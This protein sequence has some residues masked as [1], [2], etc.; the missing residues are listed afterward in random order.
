MKEKN[1]K[2]LFVLA[3]MF[4]GFNLRAALTGVGP[5]VSMIQS[6]LHLSSGATGF[7]TTIPLLAFAAMSLLVSKISAK[8][9]EGK[10]IL[11]SFLIM[12]AGLLVR[13]YLGTAGLFLGTVLAGIGI[14]FGNVL[15]PVIIKGKFPEKAAALTSVYTA[16]MGLFA[17]ISA[18]ISA[19]LALHVGW[20]NSMA[21]WA[22]LV[23]IGIL[24][25][26]PFVPMKMKQEQ[27]DAVKGLFKN[28]IAIWLS[29]FM[30]LQSLLFY[31]FVAWLP[32]I[33]AVKGF[34]AEAAGYLFSI[35]QVLGIPASFITPLLAGR[36]NDQ[37]WV[38]CLIAGAY[39]LGL[40]MITA[41]QVKAV[42]GIG[43]A[44]C[45]FCSGCC[46]S[47]AM[48]MINT[49]ASNAAVSGQLSGMS[50]AAGY[51]LAAVGPSAMGV[52]FDMTQNWTITLTI[53]IVI[54]IPLFM[55]GWNAAKDRKVQNPIEKG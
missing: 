54:M 2:V 42:I 48:L 11:L 17:S 47:I 4:I 16:S 19:P 49:R 28:P 1:Q 46:L 5:L 37:R 10:T 26:L 18:A 50:Q 12:A 27:G 3:I 13:S 21:V 7:I 34:D 45:G 15:L 29:V 51:I 35:Y 14:A 40:L 22:I 53:L 36:K 8:L 30:G 31:C 44:I 43:V 20:R 23:V 6:D 24:F 9:G 33:L 32:T 52:V 25:W 39:V 55:A 38:V 41:F